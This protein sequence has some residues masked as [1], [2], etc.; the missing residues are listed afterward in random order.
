MPTVLHRQIPLST[1]KK[2]LT[3]CPGEVED[4]AGPI[5]RPP[6][7]RRRLTAKTAKARPESRRAGIEWD[8]KDG[9]NG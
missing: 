9:A 6:I 3:T 8:A 5:P 7:K 2:H 4:E 1:F